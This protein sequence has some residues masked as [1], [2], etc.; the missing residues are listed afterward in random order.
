MEPRPPDDREPDEPLLP[1]A[2]PLRRMQAVTAAM[3]GVVALVTLLSDSRPSEVRWG[4]LV[5]LGVLA[6]AV[7]VVLRRRGRDDRG[8]GGH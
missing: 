8:R 1:D 7:G 3:I 6:I 5:G 4:T 2:R